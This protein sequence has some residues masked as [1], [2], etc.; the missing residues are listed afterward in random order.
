MCCVDRLNP[1]PKA[2][3][4]KQPRKR[5]SPTMTPQRRAVRALEKADRLRSLGGWAFG[6][7]V[8][9]FVLVGAF[10]FSGLTNPKSTISVYIG[11]AGSGYMRWLF[12]PMMAASFALV[13]AGL[14]MLVRLSAGRSYLRRDNHAAA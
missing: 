1:Q 7:G 3:I 13:V 8:I 6:L 2:D 5:D 10:G 12:L 9:A 11:L 14:I 4:R